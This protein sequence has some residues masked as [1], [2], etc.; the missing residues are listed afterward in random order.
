[1]PTCGSGYNNVGVRRGEYGLDISS[2]RKG[3]INEGTWYRK[4]DECP[5]FVG[6]NSTRKTRKECG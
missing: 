4:G 5:C 2:G 6:I 1:M 3:I